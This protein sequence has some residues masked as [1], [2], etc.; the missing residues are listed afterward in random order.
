MDERE[1]KEEVWERQLK[2]KSHLSIMME[3]KHSR[4]Y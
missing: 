2:I 1:T 4:T 3:T